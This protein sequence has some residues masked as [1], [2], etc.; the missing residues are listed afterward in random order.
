MTKQLFYLACAL[1]LFGCTNEAPKENTT[2]QPTE[3]KMKKEYPTA[4]SIERMDER[5]D[6]LIAKDAKLEILA[7]G[8]VWSEGPLWV[9]AHQMLLFSDI[10]PNSIYKWTEE[11]GKELYLTPSGYTGEEERG[12]EVGSNALILDADGRLVLCQHGDRR[13]ARMDVPV[14][15]PEAKF[16]T[17]ADRYDGKRFNSPNDAVFNSKGELFF[18]D[19]PYGLA[20]QDNDPSKE[21]DYQG[22]FRVDTSG[23]VHLLTDELTRPNGLA[24]SPD[25]SKLY[26]AN[27]DPERAIWM[28]YDMQEDGSIANGKVFY[29]ATDKVAT[30]KGLP[31]GMKVDDAGN[32]YAT[33]PGGVW[34][35]SPEGEQLGLIRT[36]QATSNCAFNADKSA[37][38]I[39]ADMYIMRLSLK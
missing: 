11:G 28:V 37:L 10:P 31:D 39:T 14:I 7:E 36:G 19:P 21:L 25:E 34:V 9:E 33:G 8:F 16:T 30:E 38:F 29:D 20:Q 3:E 12:G 6:A 15:L 17:L 32:I 22:V 2:Q 13:M 5:L 23:T 18:T 1:V 35:F 26:V 27:S 24:F 4:G